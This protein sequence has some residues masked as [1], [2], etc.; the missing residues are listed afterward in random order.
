MSHPYELPLDGADVHAFVCT[1]DKSNVLHKE[2]MRFIAYN[3]GPHVFLIQVTWYRLLRDII[4]YISIHIK[5]WM[6]E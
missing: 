1:K 2:N 6:I 3:Y 4:R 5:I